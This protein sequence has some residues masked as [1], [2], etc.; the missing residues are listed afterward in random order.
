MSIAVIHLYFRHSTEIHAGSWRQAK[1]S[2]DL[3]I[4][5]PG[6]RCYFGAGGLIILY[7]NT[8][9]N[10]TMGFV[11]Q[12]LC[13][14]KMITVKLVKTVNLLIKT[15][16]GGVHLLSSLS[17]VKKDSECSGQFSSQWVSHCVTNM[18]WK[19]FWADSAQGSRKIKVDTKITLA[20][21]QL[22]ANA[23]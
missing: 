1:G 17:L 20:P 22:T 3:A 14:S 11:P 21:I 10:D 8:M 6:I 16:I 18:G 13:K 5:C 2:H 15:K 23:K 12:V 7:L 9:G 4:W 19:H